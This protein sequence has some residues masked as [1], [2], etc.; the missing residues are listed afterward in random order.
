M[1][2]LCQKLPEVDPAH[3]IVETAKR[4]FAEV[5]EEIENT[6]QKL[7][8]HQ[9]KWKEYDAR[10]AELSCWLIS[11]ESQLRLLRNRASDPRKYNQVKATITELRNDA[12]LQEGNLAWLKARMAVLI[13]ICA[14]SDAQRQGSTLSKLSADFKGLLASL[15]EVTGQQTQQRHPDVPLPRH[16]LQLLRVEPKA[17]PGQPR[18]I[19]PPA[20]PGPSPRPPPGGTPPEEGVQVASDIDPRATSTGS[21]RCGGAAALLRAPPGW[22]SSSPYL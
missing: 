10:Y 14:E 7:M 6:H 8:Q 11:K 22:P 5:Q 17:L 13:E 20:C 2:E 19:V 4:D 12:E 16:L 15:F 3:Q 18:D 1:E 21:P 9:D